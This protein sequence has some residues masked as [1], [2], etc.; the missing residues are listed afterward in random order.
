MSAGQS[1]AAT[2]SP[3]KRHMKIRDM[4]V[5]W[6]VLGAVLA[7]AGARSEPSS[8]YHLTHTLA[9]PGEGSWDYLTF[10][11][12][13]D[14][15]FV[16]RV[17]GFDVFSARKPALVQVGAIPGGPGILANRAVLVEAGDFGFTSNGE[18]ASTTLFRLS[19]LS[20]RGV[21]P[22]GEETDAAVYDGR[23]GEAVFFSGTGKEALI[24]DLRSR[25]V[26]DRIPLGSAPE[27]AVDDGAGSIYVNIPATGKVDRIDVRTRRIVGQF[28]VAPSCQTNAAIDLDRADHLL[29]VGCFNGELDVI[30]DRTGRTVSTFPTGPAVDAVQYD[31]AIGAAFAASVDGRITSV[32]VESSAS[33]ALLQVIATPPGVHTLAVDPRTHRVFTDAADLGPAQPDGIPLFIPGTFR[34]LTYAP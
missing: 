1:V 10:D 2:G 31:P 14:R 23:T 12:S 5:G 34:V 19:D 13:H 15:L 6:A 29:F 17:G 8:T 30:D 11:R 25:K 20:V 22:L 7:P 9:V 21:V 32:E 33:Q 4:L 27:F 24:F 26:V 18:A 3:G 16:S 28:T